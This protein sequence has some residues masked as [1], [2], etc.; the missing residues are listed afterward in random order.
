MNPLFRGAHSV[1]SRLTEQVA[2]GPCGGWPALPRSHTPLQ[3][4][5]SAFYYR[6]SSPSHSLHSTSDN[7]LQHA[8]TA[9][10]ALAEEG[11]GAERVEKQHAKGKLTA[12]ERLH[13]LLDVGT[14]C[15]WDRLVVSRDHVHDAPGARR[16]I[17]GTPGDGV[18]TGHGR[19]HGRPVFVYSQDFTV[20]GGSLSET[21]A[22]KICK[23]LDRAIESRAPLIG[24]NDSGGARIQEGV[25]SLG[26]YAEV[27]KRNVLASGYIP[28]IS[29]IMGP[30]A[31]GA[32]YSPALT[33]FIFMVRRQS[34]MFLT[35]PEVIRAALGESVTSEQL[36]GADTHTRRSGVAHV[37]C[38][39]DVDALQRVRELLSYLPSWW[40]GDAPRLPTDDPPERE[41]AVLDRLVPAD[42]NEAYDMREVIERVVDGEE[43]FEIQ[44][45]W[46]PNVITTFARIDGRAVAIVANQPRHVAGCL[47]M[48]AS[49]KAARFVRFADAF[50]LPIVTLV[51]VPGFLPGTQQ[52]HH[53]I[54]RHG[55]KLLYAYTEASSPKLTVVTRKAYGGAYCVMSSKH[56]RGDLNSAWPSAEIAVM[57][58][59]GAVGVLHR[60][61]SADELQAHEAEYA[62]RYLNPLTALRRGFVDCLLQPRRTR[63]W[64][65]QGLE[66]LQRKGVDS[67][68][69]PMLPKKHGNIPL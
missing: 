57:G 55:A 51:D 33:D 34:N 53:G 4:L 31:G 17:A 7:D 63:A 56:I 23:V 37:A 49:V 50:R 48:D 32:V 18:V 10:D 45:D 68:R 59:R 2:C 27:F 12:R 5:A 36:G 9:E 25:L 30:C 65:A 26:G 35:G 29:V 28:Q 39:D 24:I 19:I 3:R 60:G 64:L 69:E 8:L 61:D 44:P 14:F 22:E 66:L 15:E 52:E 13:L 43:H 20:A 38:D 62:R 40:M 46:A 67:S 21:H 54:I 42:P 41:D 58:A 47:D 6:K 16:D 11:G 1:W